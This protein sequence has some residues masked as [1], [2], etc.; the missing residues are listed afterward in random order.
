MPRL[1]IQKLFQV[2]CIVGLTAATT[3]VG[4]AEKPDVQKAAAKAATH[5]TATVNCPKSHGHTKQVPAYKRYLKRARD[6][7]HTPR[8]G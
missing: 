5:H 6:A 1:T 7:R 2:A 8:R 4:H 3:S